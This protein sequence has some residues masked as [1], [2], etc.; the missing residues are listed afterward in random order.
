SEAALGLALVIA[1]FRYRGT[2]DSDKL[3]ILKG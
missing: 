2:V 1:L 3:T